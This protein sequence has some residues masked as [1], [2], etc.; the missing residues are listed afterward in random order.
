MGLGSKG[1][2]GFIFNDALL[3][4]WFHHECHKVLTYI[5]TIFA[6]EGLRCLVFVSWF[7]NIY[8]VFKKYLLHISKFLYHV[9]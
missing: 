8:Y 5:L 1:V 9:F 2:C 3:N 7:Q 4:H 6:L